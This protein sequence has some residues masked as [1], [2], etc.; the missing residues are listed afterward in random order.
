MTN[1]PKISV[2]I[3]FYNPGVF[4]DTCLTSV[5][6]Q[7]YSNVEILLINDGSTNLNDLSSLAISDKRIKL[8]NR[9]H[10]GV[11]A[12]RNFGLKVATGDY[13]L[14][15][16]SDDFFEADFI[17]KIVQK[18][19]KSRS[20]IAVCGFYLY[21]QRY[22][23]DIKKLTPK[24]L[25][26]KTV[27]EEGLTFDIFKLSPNIWN[28][29]FKRALIIKNQ[30]MFQELETCNDFA[31]T[32]QCLALADRISFIDLPLIHYRVNQ[33]D[34]ISSKRGMSAKNI[35]YAIKFLREKLG[36]ANRFK[37]YCYTFRLRAFCSI[38]HEFLSCSLSQKFLFLLSA[39]LILP[40]SEL[41]LIFGV[42]MKETLLAMVKNYR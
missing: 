42:G 37:K 29:L 33:R 32:Y 40:L 24:D 23:R 19:L 26:T 22:Q 1:E 15:L 17:S 38:V 25:L 41:F 4:F 21:D 3:P 10:Q 16:D 27:E 11:S 30:I 5:V 2:I 14:F 8:F 20:D 36:E 18:A 34:N 7:N 28:K 6:R 35:F 31:F 13:V 39:P 9:P 12:A